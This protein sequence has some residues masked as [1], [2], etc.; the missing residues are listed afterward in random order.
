VTALASFMMVLDGQVITT[1]FATIRGEFGASVETLQWTVNGYNLTFAVLLRWATA[2][3][4][5]RS[6]PPRCRTARMIM[7]RAEASPSSPPGLRSALCDWTAEN[8][9]RGPKIEIN[10]R[11]QLAYIVQRCRAHI[12]R[13]HPDWHDLDPNEFRL[14]KWTRPAR[15]EPYRL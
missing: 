9:L 11:C 8:R 1:A 7:A 2:S 4:A 12:A 13:D 10:S 14:V 15:G 6:A 5:P 3:I